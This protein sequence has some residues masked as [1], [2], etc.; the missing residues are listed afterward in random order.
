MALS[1]AERETLW[2]EKLAREAVIRAASDA[3]LASAPPDLPPIRDR[4]MGSGIGMLKGNVCYVF[5]TD[6]GLALARERKLTDWL[7]E[8]T[9][10]EL[11]ERQ[12]PATGLAEFTVRFCTHEEILR[13]TGGDY[14]HFFR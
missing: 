6:A 9:R 12:Y 13:K 10:R 1:E 3:A 5:E 8:Q 4:D 7:D 14:Y 2:D 11:E